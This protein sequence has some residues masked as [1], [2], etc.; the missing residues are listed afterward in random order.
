MHSPLAKPRLA[1][2]PRPRLRKS[3]SPLAGL[4]AS[5]SL[6]RLVAHFTLHPDQPLHFRAL[7]KHTGVPNRSLQTEL[8]RLDQLGLV[9]RRAHERS[10]IFTANPAAPLWGALRQI[11]RQVAEPAELLRDALA[12][13]PGIEA[14]VVYGSVA[15]GDARPDSDVDVL[16]LGEAV[17]RRLL[18]DRVMEVA[19]LLGREINALLLTRGEL[20]D[21]LASGS[22]FLG[23]VLAGPLVPVVGT[24]RVP[25]PRA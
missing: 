14:A 12:D 2:R 15:R 25:R 16:V 7:Q 5:A 8:R 18:V 13:L 22:P 10:V 24:F 23:R 11:V 1:G 20:A 9:T 21:R 19:A 4:L 6:A 17:E 3:D